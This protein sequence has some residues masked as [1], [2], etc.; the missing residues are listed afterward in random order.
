MPHTP[1]IHPDSGTLAYRHT[2]LQWPDFVFSD[3]LTAAEVDAFYSQC[4]PEFYWREYLLAHG[5]TE[6]DL[7]P[8]CESTIPP[9]PTTYQERL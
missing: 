9:S 3:G 8:L 7:V 5:A 1:F 4:W 2:P 6:E